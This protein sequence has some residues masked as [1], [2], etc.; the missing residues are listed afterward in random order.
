[1]NADALITS[2][3]SHHIL[4]YTGT[5]ESLSGIKRYKQMPLHCKGI[6]DCSDEI[7]G[8]RRGGGSRVVYRLEAVFKGG[9]ITRIPFAIIDESGDEMLRVSQRYIM[10]GVIAMDN[11]TAQQR[12]FLNQNSVS[13]INREC[14]ATKSL[15]DELT[16]WGKGIVLSNYRASSESGTEDFN[17]ACVEHRQW[18]MVVRVFS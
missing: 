4:N 7:I 17:V 16:F 13:A 14:L 15:E 10:E 9:L 12:L 2:L 5:M 11:F 6:F 18:D 1:M 3:N 8:F